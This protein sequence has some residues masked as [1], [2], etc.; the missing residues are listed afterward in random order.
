MSHQFRSSDEQLEQMLRARAAVPDPQLLGDIVAM[1]EH[2]R[3]RRS[4]FGG[5]VPGQRPVLLLA[6]VA[7]LLA[8]LAGAIAVGLRLILPEPIDFGDLESVIISRDEC[9]LIA[10]DPFSG[11]QLTIWQ[12][13]DPCEVPRR[14]V[15]IR[16][17]PARIYELGI[18]AAGSH[19]GLLAYSVS[20]HEPGQE[21]DLIGLWT[22]DLASGRVRQLSECQVPLCHYTDISADG[23][24]ILHSGWEGTAE[25]VYRLA[26]TDID[27]S[28]IW[29]GDFDEPAYEPRFSPDAEAIL[30]AGYRTGVLYAIRGDGEVLTTVF[31][32]PG[33]FVRSG[34]WSPDGRRMAF[35]AFDEGADEFQIWVADADGGSAR[36]IARREGR[37]AERHGPVWSPDGEWIAFARRTDLPSGGMF[38]IWVVGADGSGAVQV[39]EDCCQRNT[40]G[41]LP[42]WSPDGEWIAFGASREDPRFSDG[43]IE[44]PGLYLVRRDG[45]GLR[46]VA[47]VSIQPFLWQPLPPSEP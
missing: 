37:Q 44:T 25:G 8:A 17:G 18:A 27:G 7:L 9:G 21:S 31:E 47:D 34:N 38:E 32:Q 5:L 1:T 6:T 2:R 26:V 33:L 29:S 28:L 35:A 13:E 16:S 20:R 14:V 42:A 45:S 12:P 30:F 10:I 4:L 40:V 41:S 22:L 23:G 15:T 24:R 11:E 36:Q 39:Y 19:D 43:R 46:R 3:Q